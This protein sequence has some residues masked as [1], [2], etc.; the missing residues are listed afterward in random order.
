[1][2]DTIDQN[3]LPTVVVSKGS[4]E[5]NESQ[6]TGVSRPTASMSA[7][8]QSLLNV[9]EGEQRIAIDVNTRKVYAVNAGADFI[10]PGSFAGSG[11]KIQSLVPLS[12]Q[13]GRA[14]QW[15]Q[16]DRTSGFPSWGDDVED[17]VEPA[18]PY[19]TVGTLLSSIIAKIPPPAHP[20][21]T[22]VLID[23]AEGKVQIIQNPTGYGGI[24]SALNDLEA[25]VDTDE[26]LT[27][28]AVVEIEEPAT[29]SGGSAPLKFEG[30]T[31]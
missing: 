12:G 13:S 29:D 24:A 23:Q 31:V 9:A 14:L 16:A 4:M 30:G 3:G 2:S 7:V 28:A 1:M 15:Q 10:T 27:E 25:A 18:R 21:E 26:S 8:V 6:I 17:T 5:E 19:R 20:G 22:V 11:T